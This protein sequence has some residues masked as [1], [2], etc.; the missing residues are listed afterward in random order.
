M[1]HKTKTNNRTL[2]PRSNLT[3]AGDGDE[4]LKILFRRHPYADATVPDFILLDLNLPRRNGR[5]VL[6]EIKA[7]PALMLI[8]V[9][10]PTM[11]KAEE[12]INRSYKY[13]ANS[14]IARQI[15][16]NQ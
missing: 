16:M 1:A 8:P 4:A 7:A 14:Y 13:R 6:R 2:E 12:D 3:A 15:D 10:I 5:E 11:S 9:L